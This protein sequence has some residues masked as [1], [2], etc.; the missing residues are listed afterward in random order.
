MAHALVAPVMILIAVTAPVLL[1]LLFGDQWGPSVVPCQILA[2]A[3]VLT[4]S[5]MDRGLVVGNG[6]P[7]LWL[8]YVATVD[9][10]TVLAT[11]LVAPYGL[12]AYAWAFFA[13]AAVAT[14]S[15]WVLVG[16]QLQASWIAVGSPLLRTSVPTIVAAIVGTAVGF[17]VTGLNPWLQLVLIGLAVLAVYLPIVR[18]MLPGAWTELVGFALSFRGRR[19]APVGEAT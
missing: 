5:G 10:V 7:G 8:I 13:I 2:A 1:P 9:A 16:R 18:V 3:G 17:A 12:V 14:V 6:K 11:L 15:R 19:P 4:L